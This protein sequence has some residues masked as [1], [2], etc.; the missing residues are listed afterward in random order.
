MPNKQT[1]SKDLKI[2]AKLWQ[3]I[4]DRFGIKIDA[5]AIAALAAAGWD[6]PSDST[7]PSDWSVD[8]SVTDLFEDLGWTYPSE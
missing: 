8:T 2:F 6:P 5:Q 1:G 3:T 7:E 4:L